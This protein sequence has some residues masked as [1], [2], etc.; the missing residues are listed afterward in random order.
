MTKRIILAI[1]V[2]LMVSSVNAQFATRTV[3]Q[4]SIVAYHSGVSYN[5]MTFQSLY[6]G[7]YHNFKL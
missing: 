2:L 1:S 3:R 4:S 7:F 6:S 5:S